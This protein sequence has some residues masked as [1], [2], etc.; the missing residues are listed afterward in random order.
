MESI[1]QRKC[2]KCNGVKKVTIYH[3]IREE[4][5]YCLRCGLTSMGTQ[6]K[7]IVHEGFGTFRITGSNGYGQ[8]GT[9]REPLTVEKLEEFN[10]LFDQEDTD[11]E[12]SFV[13]KWENNEQ[14]VV[15]GKVPP[16]C[17]LDYDEASKL[18]EEEAKQYELEACSNVNDSVIDISDDELPF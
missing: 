9:L 6:L 5:A 18:W 15:L 13:A 17:A 16:E 3:H 12:K 7:E 14:V 2:E 11:M 10:N 1:T 8:V 4:Y